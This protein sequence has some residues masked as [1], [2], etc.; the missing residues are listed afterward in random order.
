METTQ[1]QS[2]TL[3][4]SQ[5]E[6]SNQTLS[7]LGVLG[8]TVEY[9]IPSLPFGLLTSSCLAGTI[10]VQHHWKEENSVFQKKLQWS[11]IGLLSSAVCTALSSLFYLDILRGQEGS[12]VVAWLP[13]T[14]WVLSIFAVL[15]S[16]LLVKQKREQ[17]NWIFIGIESITCA[18]LEFIMNCFRL[19]NVRKTKYKLPIRGV[20]INAV[21][22]I[23]A[24]LLFI[25]IYTGI[26]PSFGKSTDFLFEGVYWMMNLWSTILTS[27]PYTKIVVSMLILGVTISTFTGSFNLQETMIANGTIPAPDNIKPSVVEHHTSSNTIDLVQELDAIKALAAK[28]S[29]E[30]NQTTLSTSK[31]WDIETLT[32]TLI[33]L[34]VLLLW[35]HCIDLYSIVSSDL[36]SPVVLSQNVHA[37]LSRVFLATTSAIAILLLPTTEVHSKSHQ[38]WAKAWI[39]NNGVFSIWAI[40]KVG[41]YIGLCGVTTK[42]LAIL[43]VFIGLAWTVKSCF[44]MLNQENRGL[45]IFNKGIELQYLCIVASCIA[46]TLFGIIRLF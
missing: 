38:Q 34:N 6:L 35:F 45:W 27:L 39:V 43:G 44:S 16:T 23:M 31:T 14:T 40:L 1:L 25:R 33:A 26:N 41:L 17:F 12:D 18:G 19:K 22:P 4:F 28:E 7:F 13:I 5:P 9:F 46:A 29:G 30:T 3:H 42:R 15:G 20:V 32:P 8:L 10:L 24:I 21:L 36:S 11:I 2:P 37:C